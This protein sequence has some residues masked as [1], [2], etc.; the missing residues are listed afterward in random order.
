[1]MTKMIKFILKN[2]RANKAINLSLKTHCGEICEDCKGR[3][4]N[5]EDRN[6]AS[7]NA[8]GII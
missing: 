5:I 4:H 1:M 7:C 6:C 3:G 2:N 8:K